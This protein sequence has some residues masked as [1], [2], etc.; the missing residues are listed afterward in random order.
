V[1]IYLKTGKSLD[2]KL[3]QIV[4]EFRKVPYDFFDS[5][6]SVERNRIIIDIQPDE[7]IRIEFN[8]KE[9]GN[10]KQLRKVEGVFENDTHG[11]EAYEKLIE[12]ITQGDKTLFTSFEMLEETWRI[13]DRLVHCKDNCP[14]LY[15]YK[16]GSSGPEIAN[17]LIQNDGREWYVS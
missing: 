12:D 1:P 17:S 14:V 15:Q 16:K 2:K 5:D 8:V 11:K 9:I 7:T 10:S 4:I 3:T 6:N 13:I